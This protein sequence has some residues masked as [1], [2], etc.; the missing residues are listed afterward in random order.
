[1]Q[2]AL[3]GS[4]THKTSW[5]ENLN[6]RS[7]LGVQGIIGRIILVWV[8]FCIVSIAFEIRNCIMGRE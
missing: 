2:H 3:E 4:E 5:S 1:M 6:G 7:H 8:L